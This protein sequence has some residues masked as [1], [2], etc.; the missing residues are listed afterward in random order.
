MLLL[1]GLVALHVPSAVEAQL[2]EIGG[3]VGTV[4]VEAAAY[5]AHVRDRMGRLVADLGERWDDS[6]PMTPAAFYDIDATIV[7]GPDEV[8]EGRAAIQKAFSA[9]LGRM[10][11]MSFTMQEFDMSDEMAFVRGTMS[12]ELL[13]PGAA[14]IRETAAF[15]MTVRVK[16]DAWLIQS[17]TIAGRAPLPEETRD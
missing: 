4:R 13:R 8:V 11:G 3:N 7:L 17:L 14:P 2:R 6:N 12:Y 9:R 10:F 15:A 5:R 16:R 1:A